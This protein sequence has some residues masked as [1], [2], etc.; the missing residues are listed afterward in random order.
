MTV[1]STVGDRTFSEIER[2][3]RTELDPR[4]TS[5]TSSRRS[6][7]RAGASSSSASSS[8][9]SRCPPDPAPRGRLPGCGSPVHD[10]GLARDVGGCRRGQEDHHPFQV[11]R[12]AEAPKGDVG[13]HPLLVPLDQA[14]AHAGR[15]PAGGY[16]V[17]GY[18]VPR[19]AR[20]EVARH[21]DHGAL[22]GVVADGLHVVRVAADE[23]GDGGD[24]HYGAPATRSEEHTSEL[25]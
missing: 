8:T 4:G 9:T 7:S 5:P 1:A 23:A 25:Q 16:G 24:V 6:A 21:R 2:L 15:E 14:A 13:E 18:A 11:L 17:H 19:P 22:G 10:Y 3:C 12:V 20:R